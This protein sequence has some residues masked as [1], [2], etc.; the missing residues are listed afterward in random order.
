MIHSRLP[1]RGLIHDQHA[2]RKL[3]WMDDDPAEVKSAAGYD[4]DVGC[5]RIRNFEPGACPRRAA[6]QLP[7]LHCGAYMHRPFAACVQPYGI[8]ERTP[9]Q[10]QGYELQTNVRNRNKC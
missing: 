6:P 2:R 3:G 9:M 1:D 4:D 7:S 8:D 5:A 10:F